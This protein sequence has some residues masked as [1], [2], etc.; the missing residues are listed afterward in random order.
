MY[1]FEMDLDI[2]GVS[3]ASE[4]NPGGYVG[5]NDDDDD[6]DGVVDYND[7]YNKDGIPGN[8][9]DSNPD[10]DDLVQ[11]NLSYEPASLTGY[12]K[13][14]SPSGGQYHLRVWTSPTKGINNMIIGGSDEK[15]V[16]PIGSMPS[17]L[18]VEGYSAGTAYLWLLFTPDQQDYPGGTYNHD[19]VKFTVVQ[20]DR[21]EVY[22][23]DN[24]NDITGNTIVLL[25]GT[26]YSFKALPSPDGANWPSGTP[27][28]K[29]NGNTIASGD[30]TI[31]VTFDNEG[32]QELRAMCASGGQMGGKTVTIEVIQPILDTVDYK[33]SHQIYNV[34]SPEYQRDPYR[35][36]PACWTKGALAWVKVTFWHSQNLTFPTEGILVRADTSGDYWN[37]A[38]W[39]DSGPSTFGTS[40][41]SDE[42][43][44]IAE[45]NINGQ[46]EWR[47]Y[48]AT[49]K[50][51][52]PWGTNQWITTTTQNNCR[53]YV[54]LDTPRDPQAQPWKEVLDIACDLAW[55]CDTETEA[56]YEIWDNFYSDASGVYDTRDGA[57][58]YTDDGESAPFELTLWLT[59]YNG[60]GIGIVNCYDMAKAEVVFANSLGCSASNTYIEPFGYPNC[61]YP[62]GCGWCNNPFYSDPSYNPNP[63]V[64]G[65]WSIADGRSRFGNHAFAR[66]DGWIYDA[67]LGCV[68]VD[69]DPDDGPIHFPYRYLDGDDT[70]TNDYRNRVI[71]NFPAVTPGSPVDNSFSVR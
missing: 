16:W 71:D 67:S 30:D 13:L 48:S 4:E 69:L 29:L 49:W 39:G 36:E 55:G 3:D 43:Q 54:V 56:M 35:N 34:S 51:K 21:I 11:I 8:D 70:W 31:E 50:Y 52:V 41:P 58:R 10:E 45:D 32:T 19:P 57:P 46:V 40:W 6:N 60:I 47:D 44:C 62:I 22:A 25:R 64:N 53:L 61:I 18:W 68:D 28:W 20:V 59:N 14:E 5:L 23:N 1:V 12:A 15:E 7:G 2:S 63:V 27:V 17:T 24:W 65:D 37:I 26:R 42:I 9:D 66:L 33:I 38:D